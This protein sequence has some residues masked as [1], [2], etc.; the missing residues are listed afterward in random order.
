[1]TKVS[2]SLCWSL[3]PQKLPIYYLWACRH[4]YVR[5]NGEPRVLTHVRHS[6]GC[7]FL[8]RSYTAS[9]AQPSTGSKH[10]QRP[11]GTTCW[12]CCQCAGWLCSCTAAIIPTAARE[13]ACAALLTKAVAPTGALPCHSISAPGTYW[14]A[15]T[16]GLFSKLRLPIWFLAF[17]VCP[18]MHLCL[19]K[20]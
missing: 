20:Y 14:H 13:S 9:A 1:M 12:Q 8:Y 11:S 19:C 10:K 3:Q 18:S 15:V 5:S 6:E 4:A 2:C 7:N 16:P 17:V